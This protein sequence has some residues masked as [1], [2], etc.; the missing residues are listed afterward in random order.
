MEVVT[1]ERRLKSEGIVTPQTTG[2]LNLDLDPKLEHNSGSMT[3]W[4]LG[5]SGEILGSCKSLL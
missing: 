5:L 2:I 3:H 4:S 1:S